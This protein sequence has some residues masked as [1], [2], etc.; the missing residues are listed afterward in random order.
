MLLD[1]TL[2]GNSD[3]LSIDGR[4]QALQ[5]SRLTLRYLVVPA[6][7]EQLMQS[8]QFGLPRPDVPRI[9]ALDQ[10]LQYENAL[11]ERRPFEEVK[12]EELRGEVDY[13][14]AP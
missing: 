7:P 11:T 3:G 13:C 2:A 1:A 5:I 8:E 12:C 10:N 14:R 6:S 4:E 9:R